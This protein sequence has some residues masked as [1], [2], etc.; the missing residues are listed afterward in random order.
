MALKELY[1]PGL[2]KRFCWGCEFSV[3][4]SLF[5]GLHLIV[6]LCD[7]FVLF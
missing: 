6:L 2:L 5:F 1:I 4:F 7:V 3:V